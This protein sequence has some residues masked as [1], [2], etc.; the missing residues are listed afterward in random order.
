MG[1]SFWGMVRKAN[2]FQS[3]RRQGRETMERYRDAQLQRLVAH[4]RMHAPFYAERYRDLPET[5]F[6]LEDLPPVSKQEMIARYDDVVTDRR[7]R[8]ASVREFAED[9]SNL[10]TLFEDAFVIANTSGTTGLRGYV[11][12]HI[13]EWETFF[14][15]NALRP[16]PL[17][18]QPGGLRRL[19]HASLTGGFRVAVVA[20]TGVNFITPLAFLIMPP[21]LQRLSQV[22]LIS[23]LLPV[24]EMVDK[25]NAFQP[26]RLHGY[27]T[28]LEALAHKQLEGD[29]RIAPTD[30]SS[31]SEP[32]TPRARAVLQEAFGVFVENAYGATES[33]VMA[34][35]CPEGAMH[36]AMD[37]CILEPVDAAGNPVP[38]GCLS[39]KVF[40][41]NLHNFTQPIIRYEMSDKLVPLD[42]PCACGSPLPTVGL[43]G[44]EDDTFYCRAPDG[45]Y[46]GL[47]P[48]TLESLMLELTGYR[49]FQIR[50]VERNRIRITFVPARDADPAAVERAIREKFA[51][52]CAGH[53]LGDAVAVDVEHVEEVE[54]AQVSQKAKQIASLVGPP[55]DLEGKL[56]YR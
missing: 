19:I 54:R 5:G 52:H 53:G 35:E 38:P 14:A 46:V 7:L 9:I 45:A 17:P 6:R 20:G 33:W 26:D 23:T 8:L 41:T 12:A 31:S 29:L 32:L 18:A 1:M 40:I 30:I 15:L 28:M 49:M 11:A 37:G 22:E 48:M 13:D 34:K 50:Q 27:P 16:A 44:R 21:L 43:V 51:G 4:A 42:A 10:G 3:L 39:D 47:P 55:E 2:H 36:V 25:L 56:A 24:R